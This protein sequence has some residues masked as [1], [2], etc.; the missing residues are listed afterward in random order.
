MDF[1]EISVSPVDGEAAEAVSDLFNRYG[2]GG[3][4]VEA[5]APDFHS[6]TVRT[7]VPAED[8]AILRE[9]E[10]V[11]TLMGTALPGGLPEPRLRFIGENDW[12]ESWK[13]HFDVLHLSQRLVVK[14]SWREYQPAPGEVVLELDPGLAFGTGLHPTTQ[15][16]LQ[17]L[18]SWPLN[19]VSVF[20][21]GTGSG[22][23]AIA[24]AKMGASPV[25]AVDVDGVAIRVAR[26]NFARNQVAVESATGS[27]TSAGGR[28]WQIVVANILAN[29]LIEVMPDL[30]AALTG[31][32]RLILSGII[33]EQEA[34]VIAA[35]QAHALTI[36]DRRLDGDWVALVAAPDSPSHDRTFGE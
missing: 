8:E 15:L 26:E 27:A 23:L 36:V 22:I 6:L 33:A 5:T 25:R 14:P 28:R 21:V 24:A 1:V 11:L 17:L 19:G 12:A 13:A 31:A 34:G 9:I 10:V 2:Y 7:V 32:G 4:V 35:C 30:S 18:E 16:C 3:A 29:V 20:D